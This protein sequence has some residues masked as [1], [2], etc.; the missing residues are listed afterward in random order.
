MTNARIT[1]FV[2]PAVEAHAPEIW[3]LCMWVYEFVKVAMDEHRYEP[4]ELPEYAA[5]FVELWN[6]HGE[7]ENGG[8]AQ[9]RGNTDGDVAR[10]RLAADLLDHLNLT[11]HK[12]IIDEFIMFSIENE[13]MLDELYENGQEREAD[14]LFWGFDQRYY[15][16]NKLGINLVEALRDWLLQQ[17]WVVIDPTGP[18]LTIRHIRQSMSP[19]PLAEQRR[20]AEL[21][22][23]RADSRGVWAAFCRRWFAKP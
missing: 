7:C 16:L 3:P 14:L 17:A 12:A 15:E 18:M 11:D 6:Y 2:I 4:D 5:H 20:E 9:Y 10:W 21:R 19:H 1:K 8:H 23:N 22:R 13:D